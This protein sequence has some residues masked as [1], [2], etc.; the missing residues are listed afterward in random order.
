MESEPDP[1]RIDS[2][3]GRFHVC[4]PAGRVVM[5]CHDEGS[6]THYVVLLNEAYRRGF[7][8][9]CKHSRASGQTK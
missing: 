9:G 7:K 6:A 5:T 1:Y 3:A 2:D 8:S 4:D